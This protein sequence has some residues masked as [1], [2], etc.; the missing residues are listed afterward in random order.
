MI[1]TTGDTLVDLE[2]PQASTAAP[3]ESTTPPV[4][5]MHTPFKEYL[6][7]ITR[8]AEESYLLQMLRLHKGNINQ[9]AKLMDVDRK[10]I[11]RMLTEYKIDPALYRG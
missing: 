2:L 3:A 6:S 5:A 9:I 10:T 7:I 4:P 1:K 11:Y 8:H